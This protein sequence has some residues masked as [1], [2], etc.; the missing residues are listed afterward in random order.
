[1][2]GRF[3]NPKEVREVLVPCL[4][5]LINGGE[6]DTI[7]CIRNVQLMRQALECCYKK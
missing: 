6:D 4:V 7:E 5:S 1:M 2:H 3:F